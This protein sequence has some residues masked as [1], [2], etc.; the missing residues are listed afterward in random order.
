MIGKG[1]I[2]IS[3]GRAFLKIYSTSHTT[4]SFKNK[5]KNKTETQR[6]KKKKVDKKQNKKTPKKRTQKTRTK[7]ARKKKKN[8][9]LKP[10][11][12]SEWFSHVIYLFLHHNL[13]GANHLHYWNCYLLDNNFFY[14]FNFLDSS[15]EII[16]I[17][18]FFSFLWIYKRKT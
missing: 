7:K 6:K 8:Y 15:Y 10:P 3:L 5:N 4:L 13:F 12:L 11:N 9:L 18:E 16:Y 14:L 2:L 1:K 17:Y